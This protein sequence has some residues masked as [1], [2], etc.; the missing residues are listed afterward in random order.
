MWTTYAHEQGGIAVKTTFNSL[1]TS[2]T[3]PIDIYIGRIEYVDYNTAFIP[4]GNVFSA[5]LHKRKSFEHERE[6]RAMIVETPP[7]DGSGLH[8]N[9]P[10]VWEAGRKCTVDL[11][12]LI[13]EVIVSP[14]AEGW[15]VDLI[16]SVVTKYGLNVQVNHS[17]LVETPV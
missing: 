5:Y 9:S 15:L 8:P 6:V 7:D 13:H 1:A 14:L 11:E 12:T 10:D 3:D 16:G 2:F 4:E 17:N